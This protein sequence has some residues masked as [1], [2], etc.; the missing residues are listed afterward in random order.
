MDRNQLIEYWLRES[1]D[2]CICS[3][4]H[5]KELVFVS[6]R[7]RGN[8]IQRLINIWKARQVAKMLWKQG[9]IPIVPHLNSCMMDGVVTDQEFLDGCIRMLDKCDAIYMMEGYG[10]SRGSVMELEHAVNTG[11]KVR[12]YFE[13][14]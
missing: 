10:C 6:G 8:F 1:K 2:Y 12:L 3:K 11:K 7:Y 5:Y 4:N 14:Y 9:F 13:D